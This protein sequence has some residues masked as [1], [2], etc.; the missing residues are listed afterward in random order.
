MMLSNSINQSSNT[1][2]MLKEQQNNLQK[3]EK[4][5][6]NINNESVTGKTF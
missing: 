2:D 5:A 1:I 6:S 4:I 3:L